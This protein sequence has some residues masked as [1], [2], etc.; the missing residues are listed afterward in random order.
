MK[1]RFPFKS[2]LFVPLWIFCGL[3]LLEFLFRLI[4]IGADPPIF[5][6]ADTEQ[7]LYRV[8]PRLVSFNAED[9]EDHFFEREKG[10]QAI[11]IFCIGGSTVG[12]YTAGQRAFCQQLSDTLNN[13]YSKN[14]IEVIPIDFYPG[15][16]SFA[17]RYVPEI[18]EQNPDLIIL[19]LGQHELSFACRNTDANGKDPSNIWMKGWRVFENT[20]VVRGISSLF[21]PSSLPCNASKPDGEADTSLAITGILYE[22]I[23]QNFKAEYDNIL[24]HCRQRQVPVICS[25]LISN[26]ADYP[27]YDNGPSHALSDRV[28]QLWNSYYQMGI[29]SIE[30]KKY[31]MAL[32]MLRN[33]LAIDSSSASLYYQLGRVYLALGD[34]CRARRFLIHA[35]DMDIHPTRAGGAFN[36]VIRKAAAQHRCALVPLFTRFLEASPRGVPDSALFSDAIHPNETGHGLMA[37]AFLQTIIQNGWFGQEHEAAVSVEY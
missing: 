21:A 19:Y 8:N 31:K 16:C 34:T 30:K 12:G 1:F 25:E 9:R 26:L 11:R 3:V 22:K 24:N 17:S 36:A 29:E 5:I 10:D 35:N 32:D 6:P 23:I 33:A 15:C 28:V 7:R 27:P 14:E 37:E 2:K 18:L 20:R 13:R 4:G